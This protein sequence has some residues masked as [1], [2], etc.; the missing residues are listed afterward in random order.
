[1]QPTDNYKQDNKVGLGQLYLTQKEMYQNRNWCFL[2]F[3]QCCICV[4]QQSLYTTSNCQSIQFRCNQPLL[5]SPSSALSTEIN[6]NCHIMDPLHSK[7]LLAQHAFTTR[8]DLE[9]GSQTCGPYM[10][11][12][13]CALIQKFKKMLNFDYF[14]FHIQHSVED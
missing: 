4:Q 5:L 12:T 3:H 11:L 14:V 2:S 8:V 1:M 9:Q 7:S 10:M 6:C 13:T